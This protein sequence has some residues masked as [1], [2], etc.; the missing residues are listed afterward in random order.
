MAETTTGRLASREALVTALVGLWL[1]V[2]LLKFG[3]PV[4]LAEKV[5]A[6]ADLLS[7]LFMPWPTVWGYGSVVAVVG[8]GLTLWRWPERTPRWVLWLPALWLGWQLLSATQSVEPRLSALTVS[9]F[10]CCAACFYL[11]LCVLGWVRTMHW[12]WIS[13]GL[14][15]AGVLVAGFDQHFGG[16]EEARRW[17]FAYE[18]PKLTEPPSPEF[19]A[20]LQSQRIYGTLFYPNTLAGAILLTLPML[21]G[22]IGQCQGLSRLLRWALAMLL[23]GASLTCLWWSG[24][25]A[26]W[27]ILLIMAGV[28]VLGF[29]TL[30]RLRTVILV[31]GLAA[32]L[33]VF[34]ARHQGYFSAGAKSM[35][36]RLH[37]WKAALGVIRARP[38]LGSGPGTFGVMYRQVKPPE[39]EMARL[40]HNDYLQQGSD[41]GLV[42]LLGFS[43]MVLGNLG[44][45]YRKS[46]QSTA[47][48]PVWLGLFGLAMQ[49][50]VEFN[51]FIPALA[52]PQF[53]F[54]GWLWART[55]DPSVQQSRSLYASVA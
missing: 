24:S 15:F 1:G 50:F 30:T 18:Y 45:L 49:E 16:L 22:A 38:L 21:L 31:V 27:L 52:W 25:K 39:A 14:G 37:Y 17:F 53:L 11:G 23:G 13:W 55:S 26:G 48:F 54:L 12:V 36:A 43:A 2:L 47:L 32:G 28:G 29:T 9:H 44:L 51:L 33:C 20:K 42:G 5:P 34:L 6:P 8:V 19:L 46:A 4:V 3:N 41:A 35:G 7:W 40:A 10:A